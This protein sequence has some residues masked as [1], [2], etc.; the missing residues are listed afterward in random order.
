MGKCM[1]TPECKRCG[2]RLPIVPW[3]TIP[4]M[5]GFKMEDG[6]TINLCK[7]CI[8]DLGRAKEQ[9]KTDDFFKEMGL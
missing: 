1:L 2:K 9:G 7:Y 6:S 5:V 3:D 8:M 4:A